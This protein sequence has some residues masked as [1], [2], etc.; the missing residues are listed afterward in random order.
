MSDAGSDHRE[1]EPGRAGV[2]GLGL[3]GA[4]VAA[5]LVAKGWTLFGV[6]IDDEVVAT[7]IER[8][9]ISE[10]GIPTD[11][12]LV[13]VATPVGSIP[14]AVTHALANTEAVVTDVGSVK[15]GVAQAVT[16]PRF[17]PGHPMAGSEQD[18][19][20]GADPFLFNGSVWVLTPTSGTDDSALGL[21]SAIAADLGAEPV[22]MDAEAH[23][24]VVAVVSHVP[25]LTAV[26]LMAL[27]SERAV[28]HSVLLRLAAGGFRDMTRIAAGRAGIW[29]D[30]CTE[31]RLAIV[32]VL[33]SLVDGLNEMRELVTAADRNGLMD[34][35]ESARDARVNLPLTARSA[36]DL[37]EVRV[38]I[39]DRPGELAR[40]TRLATDLD[41]NVHDIETA[42]TAEG[43]GGV[44]ILVVSAGP[45]ERFVVALH[46]AGYRVATR[47]LGPRS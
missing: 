41:V 32:S 29:P 23:D 6:D 34:R 7:A 45:G 11:L 20:D 8:G 22:T 28:E 25:H 46:G 36:T 16:D 19:I 26:T 10:A 43:P 5:A 24:A 30:I 4:S 1:R 35:L 3:I 17:V 18:G 14:D 33:D 47:A 12:D 31:N 44:L 15:A 27:A 40:I 2:V 39:P 38:P 37:I 13:V 42:H 9:V 21:V